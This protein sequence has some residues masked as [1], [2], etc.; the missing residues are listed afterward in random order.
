MSGESELSKEAIEESRREA[1]IFAKEDSSLQLLRDMRNSVESIT[2]QYEDKLNRYGDKLAEVVKSELLHASANL[3]DIIK[4]EN[5]VEVIKDRL[6]DFTLAAAQAFT[7]VGG[8]GD[9]A[10]NAEGE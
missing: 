9:D 7:P 10:G 5:N 4:H 6:R 8:L 2:Y 1:E 3:R